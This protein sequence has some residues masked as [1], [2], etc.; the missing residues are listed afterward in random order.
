VREGHTLRV[1]QEDALKGI[2]LSKKNEK[3]EV[4]EIFLM[5]SSIFCILHWYDLPRRIQRVGYITL[6]E[7]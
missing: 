7:G 4:G 5:R 1:L 2:F 6:V 3:R